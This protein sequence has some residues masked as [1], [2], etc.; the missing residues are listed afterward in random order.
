MAHDHSHTPV[1]LTRNQKL[2]LDA[3]TEATQPQSAYDILDKLRGDGFKAP[4]QVYRALDSLLKQGLVHRL[5]SLSA[6][7]AC[8]HPQGEG[9][10]ATVF[11][12]CNE[13]G[14]VS[15]RTDRCISGDLRKLAKAD[16]FSV[17]QTNIEIRG[18]CGRH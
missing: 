14:G 9:R 17:T 15:E 12:I 8:Q 1:A 10:A 5:E 18:T 16:G 3:V 6:F 7:I 13:C 11:M 2:V 4:L